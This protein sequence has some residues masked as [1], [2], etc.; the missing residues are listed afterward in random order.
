MSKKI[1]AGAQAI[2]L[3][4]KI[5]SGAFM[6]N[7]EDGKVLAKLMVAIGERAGRKTVSLLS[8]MNQPLGFA[9]GNALEVREAIETLHGGGPHDFRE[10]CLVVAEHMLVLG[11]ICPDL[12]SAR[13]VCEDALADGR[14]FSR[15][16]DLISAQG[17][18]LTSV[19]DPDQLPAAAL[20]EVVPA[21]RAGYL[22][23]IHARTIGESAVELGAG[24]AKKGDQID[25]AVGF[26]IH[27][28]VGDH[29][30]MGEPLFTVYSN[31]QQK[32]VDAKNAVLSAH[33]WS[34]TQVE[35]LPLFY[36]VIS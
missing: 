31:D 26:V 16:R 36:G 15:F 6:Q 18:D 23:T 8:E 3:D 5:G 29:V 28:K 4:V 13:Q 21:P 35:P 34:D 14:A 24:R 17:G 30:E 33:E 7:L 19:D 20:K 12:E 11:K 25:L 32:L 2:V 1:A 27:H 9:V 10:H 22:K